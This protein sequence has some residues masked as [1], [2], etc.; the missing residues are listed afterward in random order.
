MAS[1]EQTLTGL[2]WFVQHT[3]ATA[4]DAVRLYFEPVARLRN[5]FRALSA[6]SERGKQEPIGKPVVVRH[7]VTV[8][9]DEFDSLLEMNDIIERGVR[10][11]LS[12]LGEQSIE[13]PFSEALQ[14]VRRGI[15][16]ERAALVKIQMREMKLGRQQKADPQE[17]R[18]GVSTHAPESHLA[19]D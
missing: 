15:L 5:F 2:R 14:D 11:A 16:Q 8:T 13:H 19:E 6:F 18:G 1:N 9:V 12:E 7:I 10:E 4:K 3:I 17:S